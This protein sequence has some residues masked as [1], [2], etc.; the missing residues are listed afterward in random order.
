MTKDITQTFLDYAKNNSEFNE[1]LALV[2]QNST[3]N[4]WLIGGFVYRNISSVL[5]GTPVPEIDLDFIVETPLD[6][7]LPRGWELRVNRY[8]NPKWVN[9]SRQIDFVP[10]NT[11]HSIVRR[12]I[13]PTIQNYLTGT[14]LTVQSIAYD[15]N[16][17]EII[18]DIGIC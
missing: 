10:I 7:Q 14:P 6:L 17:R 15:V 8:N 2:K 9:G 13:E 5:Y 4:I 1:S 3:G 12:G 11:V 18:G 16:N